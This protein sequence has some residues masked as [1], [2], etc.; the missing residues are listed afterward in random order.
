LNRPKGNP[1]RSL[2]NTK[3]KETMVMKNEKHQAEWQQRS[4]KLAGSEELE[5]MLKTELYD[6]TWK[7]SVDFII[8]QL[9]LKKEMNV[10][11]AGFGWGRLIYGLKYFIPD[12]RVE[13]V[14]LTRELY[15]KANSLMEGKKAT[16]VTLHC[17]DILNLEKLEPNQ[18]DAIYSSRV[19]HY[20]QDKQ[21]AIDNLYRLLK[22]SSKILIIIPNKYCPYRW[23]TYGNPLYSIVELKK[24]MVNSGFQNIEWG[25]IGYMPPSFGR[26]SHTS[27]LYFFEKL[28]Q[29]VPGLNKIGGLAYAVGTKK[30]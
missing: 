6:L 2:K 17:D 21:K 16:K 30:N 11:E 26:Y 29:G 5:R 20:I 3:A 13:G 7:I 19:L 4:K 18:F 12:I 27:K 14:E 9:K 28:F 22:P 25:S 15:E 1:Y 8:N 23:F 10:F 24:I